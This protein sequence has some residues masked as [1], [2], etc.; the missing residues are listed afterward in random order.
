LRLAV[1]L[2][3]ILAAHPAEHLTFLATKA[4]SPFTAQGFTHWF[5]K[6]CNEAVLP[7]KPHSNA[8]NKIPAGGNDFGPLDAF[9]HSSP[10]IYVAPS[11]PGPAPGLC[12]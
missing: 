10:P 3:E 4:G 8:G 12:L 9:T 6:T 5:R 7:L 1:S 2:Q 11:A